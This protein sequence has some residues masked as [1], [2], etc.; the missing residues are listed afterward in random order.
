MGAPFKQRL[1]YVLER[2]GVF[3]LARERQ[4]AALLKSSAL[5]RIPRGRTTLFQVVGVPRSG[6]TLLTMLL[7]AQEG[8]A[9][10]SEPFLAFASHGRFWIGEGK[11]GKPANTAPE[12]Y[13]LDHP[14]A[15]I[16][17]QVEACG[18]THIGFKETYRTPDYRALPTERFLRRNHS[19]GGVDRT[20]VIVRDPKAVWNSVS[21]RY[22]ERADAPPSTEFLR[23]WNRVA[24][25][26]RAE[27]LFFVRYEDLVRDTR[28]IFERVCTQ[29]GIESFRLPDTLKSHGGSG[30][31]RA[32]KG[33][34]VFTSS[35][36]KFRET[37][38]PG[39]SEIILDHCGEEMAALGYEV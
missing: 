6:T 22:A 11:E 24:E 5:V 38:A 18:H 37:L 36:E 29:L 23:C 14:T 8:I 19:M 17:S 26:I 31:S 7:D 25:W 13:C 15:W 3:R 21:S 35:V 9:C 20:V 34:K 33:G 28:V 39:S 1:N 2:M 16:R 12:E 27:D 4:A 32:M 10:L 30:D